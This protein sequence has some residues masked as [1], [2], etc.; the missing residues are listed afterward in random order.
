MLRRTK[1]FNH[2][3]GRVSCCPR[4]RRRVANNRNG[5]VLPG[6]VRAPSTLTFPAPVSA[7]AR[8][9]PLEPHRG[10]AHR[11]AQQA[12]AAPVDHAS[13]IIVDAALAGGQPTVS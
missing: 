5:W 7:C 13:A 2:C 12:L 9:M 11:H 3:C 10:A 8:A 1:V 6:P 4:A